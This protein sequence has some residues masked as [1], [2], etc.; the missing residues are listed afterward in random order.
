MKRFL[1]LVLLLAGCPAA[2]PSEDPTPAP[3]RITGIANPGGG[4]PL[5][6]EVGLYPFPSDY[7]LAE[8]ATSPTGRRVIIPDGLLP[9]PLHPGVFAEHDGFTRMPALLTWFDAAVDAATLPDLED[10]AATLADDAS[11]RLLR[12]D[13]WERV[14]ALVELDQ[15][16]D[17]PFDQ[18]L[19]VRPRQL[20]AANTGYV[21]LVTSAARTRSGQ[22]LPVTDAFRALRDGLETD[23]EATEAW[24]DRFGLVA[25]AIEA[26]GL[27]PS[28]VVQ[29]WSFHTRSEESVVGPLLA[30][31]D[32]AMDATLPA[33][34][35]LEDA[36]DGDDR[37]VRGTFVAPDFLGEDLTLS[38]DADGAPVLEG[39][40]TVEFQLTL[41]VEIDSTR[42][43]VVY[44]HGFFSYDEEPE[45]GTLN[46]GLHRWQVSALST[47]FLGFNEFDA[48][49]TLALLGGRLDEAASI[50]HQQMQ[51]LVHFTLLGRL[52]D[53]QLSSDPRLQASDGSPLLAP[54]PRYMGISNGGTQGLTIMATSPAFTLGALVVPGGAWGHM[55][56]R[57]VQWN[58]MGALLRARY[59]DQRELQLVMSL[60]QALLDPCDSINYAEHLLDDRFPGRPPVRI[61][62]H[63]ALWDSQVA[64][65]V[66]HWVARTAGIPLTVPSPIDVWG[67]PTV[68]AD[69]DDLGV[70]AALTVYDLGVD[71]IPPGNIAP[72]E[73][74]DTHADIRAREDYQV[75]IGR[76]L[77][78]GTLSVACDG[79]CGPEDE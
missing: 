50:A 43:A 71:P 22:A 27:D 58:D 41:P 17:L 72:L 73:D 35:L 55:L 64:N 54:A 20:L 21:V 30:M 31:Q 49:N 40:R 2:T 34:E 16:T 25:A 5:V 61:H 78:D 56:Q 18:A 28:D 24:R 62:L 52:V 32:A 46:A 45:W 47:N 68:E 75:Q 8:D 1:P 15:N 74:N 38:L 10:P 6:P 4:D 53:E 26:E 65:V 42:P 77:E 12:E 39:E 48:A 60:V 57:A 13:T 33:W 23:S 7:W 36:V 76:F 3:E 9:E 29:G 66:T 19:I 70:D 37:I 69:A 14:P 67:L 51:S 11:V 44:G 59:E 63:E 79:P